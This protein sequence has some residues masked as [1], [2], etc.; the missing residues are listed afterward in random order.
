MFS[1]VVDLPFATPEAPTALHAAFNELA[2]AIRPHAG[3]NE[4]GLLTETFW[5]ALHG[6]TTLTRGGRL[7]GAHQERRLTLLLARFT[8][9]RA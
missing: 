5:A 7:P 1:Q 6:L 9:R 4:V 2:E 3:D 8:G